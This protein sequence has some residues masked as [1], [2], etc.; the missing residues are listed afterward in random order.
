[1]AI[2]I[3]LIFKYHNDSPVTDQRK[4]VKMK[5]DQEQWSSRHVLH[6][7][8]QAIDEHSNGKG[9]YA[10][11]VRNANAALY[12]KLESCFHNGQRPAPSLSV[13]NAFLTILLERA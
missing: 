9:I 8:R 5:Y 1:M 2:R 4:V 12:E 11:M 13:K 3:K 7:V 10:G 6:M